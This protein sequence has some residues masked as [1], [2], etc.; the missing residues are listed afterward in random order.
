MIASWNASS[1]RVFV[2]CCGLLMMSLSGCPS[3]TPQGGPGASADLKR[4]VILTN[5]DDPFWDAC[6]A[7]ALKAEEELKLEEAGLTVTFERADFTDKG[8]VDKLKQYSLQKDVV[9]L[10]ISVFNPDSPAVADELRALRERGVKVVTIDGDVNRE[11]FRD[12]RYAYL[13]TDNIIG[14]RELGRAAKAL[15]PEGA[16]FAFFVGSTSA[17]NAIARMDGFVEGAGE[18]FTEVER[19][20]DRGDRPTARK[21]VQDALD[22]H[23]EIDMLVG[24]WAYN[25]PQ[26]VAVVKD[27]EIRD[28]TKV[29]CF[30]AA[31]DSIRGMSEGFVD[32]MV[33]Q[34]PYEMGY[35]GVELLKAMLEDDQ[36][37]ITSMYPD[38]AQEGE[39]DIFR[40]GLRVVVPSDEEAITPDLFEENT[41]FLKL[42]EFTE[43]LSE[44]G[45]TSS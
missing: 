10:G 45:L 35:V 1:R 9:A 21:N 22:R 14:G 44:R 33:V 2:A 23:P 30:D 32:V 27:R 38:Y 29:V 8:Q 20:E 12:A 40:T 25:T 26:M 41:E 5:G 7:G 16:E 4:I 39:R 43:W 24:I 42:E 28:K 11:K 19:L 37:V 13:G 31:E 15:S 6:E 17:F 34:N 3:E 18:K 36:Q